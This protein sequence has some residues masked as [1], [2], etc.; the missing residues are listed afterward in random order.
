MTPAEK[1]YSKGR[2]CR[3]S[4]RVAIAGGGIGGMAL[5]LSLYDAGFRDVDVYESASSVKE[6]GVGINVLPHATR[7]LTELGL[8]EELYAVGIPTAELHYYSKYG[9][10]IWSEPRGINAGYRWPQF[11]IHRGKLLG[12]LHSAVM[13]RLGPERVHCGHHLSRFGQDGD[14]VWADF[15]D[16]ASGAPR[17]C[18]EADILVG[19]DG[20][21]SVIRQTLFPNEGP[22]KWNG[23]TMWRA[24]TEGTPFLSDGAM[25]M[26]GHFDRQV[27]VYPISRRYEAEGKALINWVTGFKNASNQPMPTQGW[28]RTARVEDVLEP[29]RSFVFDFLDVPALIRG[30]ETIYQYPMV[31]RDPLPTW[32]FGRVTLLGDAAHPMYP[33]GSNGASQAIIDA[34]VLARELA[35]Q[36]SVEEA[37]AAYDAWR[38]PQTA[39]VVLANRQ[40]GPER[41]LGIVEQ[42][43]PDGFV[44]VD[45]VVSRAELEEISRS[46]KRAAGF[47]PDILNNRPSLGI[48]LVDS[49]A[50]AL[51][52]PLPL[53]AENF[54]L[55]VSD[56]NPVIGDLDSILPKASVA[57]VVNSANRT[58]V[59]CSPHPNAVA[60]FCWQSGDNST[61]E[62]YPQG[63]TSSA[64]AG[65]DGKYEGK[66]VVLTSWYYNGGGD[67]KGVRVSFVDFANPS[68]PLYRHVLLVE[69]YMDGARRPNFRAVSVHA[70]GVFWYGHYLYVADTWGGLR[71][72]DT[73]HIWKVSTGDKSKIG[74]Q[75]DGSYHAHD[76]AY[77][78]PQALTFAASTT[79]GYPALRYSA[80][81]L[82]RTS[83]PQS[84]IVPEYDADGTSTRV[85]RYPIDEQTLL[86][87]PSDD[88][89][90]H[91]NE[92]YQVNIRSMQGATAIA[93]KFYVSSSRGASTQGAVYTFTKTNGPTEH[94]RAL[95][96]GP[97]DFSYWQSKDQLWTLAEHPNKRS[98]LAIKA[99]SF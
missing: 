93:E 19:C 76:Y 47:D 46:Y 38:R 54:R 40:G 14:R 27:V 72:F 57:A 85:V 43:A 56:Y 10:R 97:E 86:L 98:V 64:D 6:L 55:R 22:P 49:S 35:L 5:A 18:V 65:A 39:A 33:V 4:A 34:R 79:G 70:G 78:L 59:S 77:A 1:E 36:P 51:A 96:P 44:E 50:P 42:R 29:F 45:A 66:T 7:E 73:R 28:D 32:N 52:G 71:V 87:R 13:E 15:V 21:H 91:G 68:A 88:G 94:P 84:V 62:W 75:P 31:D 9:R 83:S 92:A 69:P 99:S 58:G 30:A 23:I 24:V 82:D 8:L 80:V 41:C 74:R 89:Y 3:R 67:N 81:S 20:I 17:S 60:A 95:P 25:V 26:I 16:R 11:S 37:V 12:V 63:I 61:T 48:G 90:V 53:K 2:S